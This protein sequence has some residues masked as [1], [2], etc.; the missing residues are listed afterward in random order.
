MTAS[1]PPHKF[2]DGLL[3]GLR[4]G[5]QSFLWMIKILVPISFFTALLE[6]SGW[7]N[8]IDFLIQPLMGWLG[9]PAKAALPLVIGMLTNIYGGIA[10]MIMLP[11]T[12]EQMTLI[13]IFLLI[14][15]NLIQEGIIQGKSGIHPLKATLF[16]IVAACI[17]VILVGQFLDTGAANPL[18]E[19]VLTPSAQPF[20]NMLQNWIVATVRL[21]IKIFLIIISI[22]T[23]VE[24][25]KSYGWIDRAV[26]LLAPFLRTLGLSDKVGIL[27][28]AGA[29]FGLVY[30]AALIVEE[31]KRGDLSKEELEGLHLS[32]GINHAVIE[33]PALFLSLGLSA[34]WLWVPRLVMAI[35]AVR[36]LSLWHLSRRQ[37]I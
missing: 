15:H 28:L 34:F 18:A 33:D 9:L 25:L 12:K 19:S 2:R 23:V 11:F 4:Q 37:R 7:L 13:A 29:F 20:L 16:R 27:W 14:S 30:G 3:R 22:L 36:L 32:I 6:W 10:A 5:L 24:I 26:T 35:L 8:S 17:T 1:S 21:A 31:A